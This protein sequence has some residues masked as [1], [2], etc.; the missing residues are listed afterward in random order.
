LE[1]EKERHQLQLKVDVL[2]K[3]DEIPKKRRAPI[4]DCFDSMAVT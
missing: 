4:I 1:F 3:M 2:K